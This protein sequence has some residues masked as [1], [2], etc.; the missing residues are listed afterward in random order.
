MDRGRS[1][2][3]GA[4]RTPRLRPPSAAV[5]Y[6]LPAIPSL[7][8][9]NIRPPT[10]EAESN[11]S[12]GLTQ[13]QC[14]RVHTHVLPAPPSKAANGASHL[15]PMTSCTRSARVRRT[16]LPGHTKSWHIH[17]ASHPRPIMRVLPREADSPG[18]Q[19]CRTK[20]RWTPS[21][22]PCCRPTSRVDGFSCASSMAARKSWPPATTFAKS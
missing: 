13:P 14:T 15:P 10:E 22:C 1:D 11:R 2:E 7:P 21:T 6:L 5:A 16:H 4:R 9:T 8:I 12:A 19:P 17:A 3:V 18:I 20:H